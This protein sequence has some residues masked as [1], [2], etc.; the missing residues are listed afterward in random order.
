MGEV[1]SKEKNSNK[2]KINQKE[3]GNN[4]EITF[5]IDNQNSNKIIRRT[6]I[7]QQSQ[8][9][10]KNNYLESNIKQDDIQEEI[11][12]TENLQSSPK[13]LLNN[14]KLE[15]NTHYQQ[16]DNIFNNISLENEKYIVD[17]RG[18]CEPKI[19]KE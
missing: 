16:H 18:Y 9:L 11:N 1:N 13:N 8:K 2:N 17:K 4:N 19:S 5:S 14:E 10:S 3:N 6:N 7:L 12:N 15:K